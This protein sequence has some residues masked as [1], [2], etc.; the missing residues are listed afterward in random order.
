[1]AD[2]PQAFCYPFYYFSDGRR[3]NDRAFGEWLVKQNLLRPEGLRRAIPMKRLGKPD[4][5]ANAVVFLASNEASYM[6]GQ[7]INV[8]GGLWLH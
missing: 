4:E 5:M 8:T 1:M 3:M 7:A 6:T 2:K